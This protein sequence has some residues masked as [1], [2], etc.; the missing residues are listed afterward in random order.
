MSEN[1][2]GKTVIITGASSG[3][4]QAISQSVSQHGAEVVALC[5]TA[6]NIDG[7]RHIATDLRDLESIRAAFDT[8]PSCDALINNAGM[9]YCSPIM[10]GGVDE[11]DEMWEVNVRALA[12]CSHLALSRLTAQGQ[13]INLSSMSGHRV[14][15]SGGFYAPT[16][17][18]VRAVTEALRWELKAAGS[19]IRVSSVSPGFV[20]TPLLDTYFQGREE[21]L[22]STKA[23]TQFLTSQDIAQQVL[24]ILQT[25]SHV[26]VGDISL[27][28]ASQSV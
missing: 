2:H 23:T 6:P 20:D 3:I 9:A 7:I 27:R 4:G 26:E 12:Y 13:V 28:S 25:P 15:P 1:L 24:A 8:I 22:A 11:W 19:P 14:P 10:E 21:Q 5:R 18:A 16:K 17:F